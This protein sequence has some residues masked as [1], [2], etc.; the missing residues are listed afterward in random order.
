MPWKGVW[1]VSCY[2]SHDLEL[3]SFGIG[4]GSSGLIFFREFVKC[5][6]MLYIAFE[7]LTSSIYC[8]DL[9]L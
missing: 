3:F 5:A 6:N 8:V 1:Q 4:A 9:P 7:I 2:D